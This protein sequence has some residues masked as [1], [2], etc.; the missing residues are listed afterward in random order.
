MKKKRHWGQAGPKFGGEK[1][2]LKAGEHCKAGIWK[3]K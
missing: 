3:G 1:G 2:E